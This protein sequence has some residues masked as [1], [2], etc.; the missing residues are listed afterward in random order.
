[1]SDAQT[2][3]ALGL[4][5]AGAAEAAVMR[6]PAATNQFASS[7]KYGKSRA[8]SCCPLESQGQTGVAIQSYSWLQSSSGTKNSRMNAESREQTCEGYW[9]EV[10]GDREV[11]S[12]RDSGG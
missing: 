6:R 2:A 8:R 11:K 3:G 12:T 5:G 4:L 9:E 10:R 7:S 1:M